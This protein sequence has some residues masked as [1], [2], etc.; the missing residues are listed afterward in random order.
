MDEKM[1]IDDKKVVLVEVPGDGQLKGITNIDKNG[2]AKVTR[3]DVSENNLSKLFD[4]NANDSHIANNNEAR[5][6]HQAGSSGTL[7]ACA[8]LYSQET[9][10]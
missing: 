3:A 7:P 6:D 2:N 1:K 9:S 5:S 4:V 8:F 10:I